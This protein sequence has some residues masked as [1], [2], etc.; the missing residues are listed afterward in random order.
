MDFKFNLYAKGTIYIIDA[1]LM[2]Y[3]NPRLLSNLTVLYNI[4]AMQNNDNVTRVQRSVRSSI[5]NMN[6]HITKE[7]LRSF[8]HIYDNDIVTPK[9]FF[10]T[11][12]DYLIDSKEKIQSY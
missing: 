8:F 7:Q 5:D 1:I 3:N 11:V 6:N 9:Y 2:S 12:L 10:T 4:I